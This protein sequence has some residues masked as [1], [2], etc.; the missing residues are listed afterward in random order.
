M[1]HPSGDAV[2]PRGV[3]AARVSGAH[4][5]GRARFRRGGVS[6]WHAP[7]PV[8][9]SEATRSRRS[10]SRSG[11]GSSWWRSLTMPTPTASAS[12]LRRRSPM[13]PACSALRSGRPSPRSR[14]RGSSRCSTLAGRGSRLDICCFSASRYGLL[15]SPYDA[16]AYGLPGMQYGQ[17]AYGLPGSHEGRTT[18]VRRSA[19]P[20]RALPGATRSLRSLVCS[21]M[22][23]ITS[24]RIGRLAGRCPS[25][26]E[27][28]GE[29]ALGAR[30]PRVGRLPAWSPLRRLPAT[31]ADEEDDRRRA[32]RRLGDLLRGGRNVWGRPARPR[33]AR[34]FGA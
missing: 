6:V 10:T 30:Q 2:S 31:L 1:V 23:S 12:L 4:R 25:G 16:A 5:T 20:W 8:S 27:A 34:G 32:L 29:L 13:R 18:H 9:S 28:Q 14:R 19:A 3:G 24:S 21:R 33:Y 26:E 15:G 7:P 17:S 11:P 22:D